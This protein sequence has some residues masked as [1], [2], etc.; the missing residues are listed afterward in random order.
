[1]N[2]S[3]NASPYFRI[4]LFLFSIIMIDGLFAK[5]ST[6]ISL[7]KILLGIVFLKSTLIVI[8]FLGDVD[9]CGFTNCIRLWPTEIYRYANTYDITIACLIVLIGRKYLIG[10]PFVFL[11]TQ[12]RLAVLYSVIVFLRKINIITLGKFFLSTVLLAVIVY[13]YMTYQNVELPRVFKLM[14]SSLADKILQYQ[15]FYTQGD[16]KNILL[17]EGLSLPIHGI[18][19]RDKLRPYSYEAQLLALMIQGG[20]LFIILLLLFMYLS[21]KSYLSVVLYCIAG[22]LNPM[23]FVLSLYLIFKFIKIAQTEMEIK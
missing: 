2:E 7:E 13:F 3:F 12:T 20:L 22:M 6:D 15:A 11:I 18:E 21:T 14:D 1:M 16:I 9:I 17:G 4:L 10:L 19:I 8:S 5:Y 23:M